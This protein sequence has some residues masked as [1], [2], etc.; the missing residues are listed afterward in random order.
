MRSEWPSLVLM[1]F[2][3]L[4]NY[5][6]FFSDLE[7]RVCFWICSCLFFFLAQ[8]W[9]ST[10]PTLWTW[11]HCVRPGSNRERNFYQRL[12]RPHSWPQMWR[13]K[14]SWVPM[15][16]MRTTHSTPHCSVSLS[17]ISALLLPPLRLALPPFPSFPFFSAFS[18]C[19]RPSVAFFKKKK[20]HLL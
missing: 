9:A 4:K 5:V 17:V 2:S 1:L 6:I 14:V 13:L 8:T 15:A 7:K 11:A 19:L 20:I 12:P 18:V 16:T 3:N 10:F